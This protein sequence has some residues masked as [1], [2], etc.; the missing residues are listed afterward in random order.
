[1]KIKV[2]GMTKLEQLQELEEIGI[3]FAGLIFYD[4]SP[5][6][7]IR[8]GLT[9]EILRAARLNIKKIGVFVNETQEDVLRIAK[10]WELDY[11]QL[12]GDESPEYCAALAE[13]MKVIKA[14]RIGDKEDIDNKVKAYQD[15]VDM[16]L[17]DTLGAQYGGTGEKFDWEIL[18]G[19]SFKKPFFL[20]G[21]LAFEDAEKLCENF[22]NDPKL[23]SLDINSRF[24]TE[25]GTK[26]INK[27]KQF[28]NKV[29]TNG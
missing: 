11:V 8:S 18:K 1:M 15:I 9:A 14:F 2:C 23:F 19:S 25:P 21:G 7:V 26:D 12:H 29:K 20:S 3:D 27:I 10:E 5:R 24:E 22:K 28:A 16:F 13:Q 4:K 6:Y 17:Y